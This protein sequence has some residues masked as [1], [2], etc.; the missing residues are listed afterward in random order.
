MTNTQPTVRA[1]DLSNWPSCFKCG[2]MMV[3]T[4]IEPHGTGYDARTFECPSCDHSEE[5]VVHF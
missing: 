1:T 3:L 2:T 5:A 4:R